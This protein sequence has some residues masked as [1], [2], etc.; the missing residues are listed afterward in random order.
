MLVV[1]IDNPVCTGVP[2]MLIAE[3][4]VGAK[5]STIGFSGQMV[6]SLNVLFAHW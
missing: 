6:L 3:T 1:G 5:R 2:D 4:P